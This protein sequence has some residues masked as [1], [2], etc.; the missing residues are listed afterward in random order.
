MSIAAEGGF[1]MA[2][3]SIWIG[4]LATLLAL[5]LVVPVAPALAAPSHRANASL[6]GS[7]V[8]EIQTSL[9]I[10]QTVSDAAYDI[11][12][13]NAYCAGGGIDCAQG[14]DA[15]RCFVQ[16]LGCTGLYYADVEAYGLPNGNP[17]GTP[18][19]MYV[20]CRR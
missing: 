3:R 18:A 8:A 11:E 4:S 20:E 9:T 12:A 7:G 14:Y 17:S 1:G 10:Q 15:D 16:N 6:R 2:P 5:T 13:R 19:A